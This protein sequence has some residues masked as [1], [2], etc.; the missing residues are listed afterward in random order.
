M[1][2]IGSRAFGSDWSHAEGPQNAE[3]MCGIDF[4]N[5]NRSTVS[6][7][8]TPMTE[9]EYTDS[10]IGDYMQEH[11]K[12]RAASEVDYSSVYWYT[13]N[14]WE[15]DGEIFN[16]YGT[17]H[18]S[19]EMFALFGFIDRGLSIEEDWYT[20]HVELLDDDPNYDFKKYWFTAYWPMHHV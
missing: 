6:N 19:A 11:I 15:V 7:V 3:F 18:N 10:Y 1:G 12:E 14:D 9:Y 2:L 17:H 4:G 5:H 20:F 16:N 13:E 8:I